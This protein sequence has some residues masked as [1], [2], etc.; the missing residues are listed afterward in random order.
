MPHIADLFGCGLKTEY[1]R[2]DIVL[3]VQP[4][5]KSK[6]DPDFKIAAAI[7]HENNFGGS[8]SEIEKLRALN[9]PLGVLI[10]Y[11]S[12][13]QRQRMLNQ[14]IEAIASHAPKDT[15]T[16]TGELLVI[17]GPYGMIPPEN[18]TWEYFVYREG[19]FSRVSIID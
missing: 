14:Y 5:P 7:E 16:M 9:A 12:T 13:H 15:D 19:E 10:T 17:F 3:T 18:L 1:R 2:I 8:R 11:A 4:V 6:H